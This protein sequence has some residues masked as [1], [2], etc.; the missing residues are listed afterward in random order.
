MAIALGFDGARIEIIEMGALHQ[1]EDASLKMF[2]DWLAGG[3]DL[4]PPTWNILI[5]SLRA[6]K[7]M[8]TADLLDRT[9][10]IVSMKI[11]ALSC[12]LISSILIFMQ[13]AEDASANN[14]LSTETV[15]TESQVGSSTATPDII[16]GNIK[17]ITQSVKFLILS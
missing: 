6:A 4:N 17:G 10:D 11:N 8:E 16:N 15:D 7:L 9:I 14:T 5:Q 13:E 3:H 12:S 2:T 1:P